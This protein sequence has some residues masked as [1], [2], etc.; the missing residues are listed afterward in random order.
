MRLMFG[1][2]NSEIGLH[3]FIG[4]LTSTL[5]ADLGASA[6]EPAYQAFRKRIVEGLAGHEAGWFFGAESAGIGPSARTSESRHPGNLADR[7]RRIREL[8]RDG[9][10][11]RPGAHLVDGGGRRSNQ[12]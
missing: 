9:P 12:D 1:G 4:R 10:G 8:G 7:F 11:L 3:G 6:T 2:S 5:K